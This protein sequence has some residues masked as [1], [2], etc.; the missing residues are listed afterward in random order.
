M[1]EVLVSVQTGLKWAELNLKDVE[2]SGDKIQGGLAKKA[3]QA[4]VLL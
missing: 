2:A 1:L 3:T 4:Q